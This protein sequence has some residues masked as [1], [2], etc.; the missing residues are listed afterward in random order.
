MAKKAKKSTEAF[1]NFF[2][3]ACCM[4]YSKM[5]EGMAALE[6]RMRDADQV[7]I[8]GPETDLKFSIKGID[9]ISCGGTHTIPD[10]EVFSCPV[11]DSVQGTVTFNADTIYQGSA[12]SNISLSFENGK[13][14]E[15]RSSSNQ[16]RLNEILDS[17]N[18]SRYIGEFAIAFN[19][20]IKEPMLDILFDEKIDGS[21]HFTPGQAYEEANNGNKSQVHWDMVSIQRP[22]WGGGEIWF[23][24]ELIRKD[25]VFVAKDLEK[26]N[27]SHL[28]NE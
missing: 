4:D 6:K 12:F 22:D 9:A 13:I 23:D 2:F 26:L 1:E 3:D 28:L 17:D 11:K 19:P 5:T 16:D 15:A 8:I 10:G 25:G 18:G 7:K 24:G 27:P 14:V 21:F 20:M